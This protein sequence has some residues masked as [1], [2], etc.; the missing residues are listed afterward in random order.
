MNLL[1]LFITLINPGLKEATV[2]INKTYDVTSAEKLLVMINNVYGDVVV[3]PSPD[4]KVHV[5]LKIKIDAR[6]ET[7]LN[8]AKKDLKLGEYQGQDSLVFYT[9]A[10]F[11]RDCNEPPFKGSWW[12]EG[13]DYSFSYEYKVQIPK[14]AMVSAKTIND[15]RV[16]VKN[17]SGTVKATN[18][19]G[20]VDIE[21]AMD[22][23]KASSVNG[24]ITINFVKAPTE[25]IDFHT[26][27]G[28][29]NLTLP[30]NFAAKVYFKSMNGEMYSSFDYKT[31]S[32]KVEVSKNKSGA[33]FKIGSKTGVEIGTGGPTLSFESING[34]VYLKN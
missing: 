12:N 13:P 4:G 18:V 22:V 34:N 31:L 23:I 21:N 10:P 28:D 5:L 20:P 11:I 9:K 16:V 8:Q 30:K 7:L 25:S 19:N 6:N 26:V 33:K 2:T 17:I 27:N 15:G 3:E 14:M 1:I 29:F 32:P 24:D